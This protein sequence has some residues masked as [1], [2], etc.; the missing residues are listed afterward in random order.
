MDTHPEE[1]EGINTISESSLPLISY[2]ERRE[3]RDDP[4]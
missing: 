2:G 1:G 4:S 3:V